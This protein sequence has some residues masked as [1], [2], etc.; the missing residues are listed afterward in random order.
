M[1]YPA[2]VKLAFG[3]TSIIPFEELS[4]AMI[5]LTNDCDNCRYL[6]TD[7]VVTCDKHAAADEE[8]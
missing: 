5:A 7:N 1:R 4:P 6:P 2:P 8:G 3:D